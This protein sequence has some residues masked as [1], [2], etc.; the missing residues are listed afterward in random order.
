[1]AWQAETSKGNEAGKIKYEIVRY[2]RGR[3]LDLGSGP[4]KPYEHFISVDNLSEWGANWRP[5][6]IGDATDLSVFAN[7]SFDAVF[8]SHL[9]EHIEDYGHALEEWWRVI[10][11]KGYLVLYLPHKDY[12][13]NIGQCGANPDHK[14]DFLPRDIISEMKAVGYWD[15]VVNET[16]SDNDEYS[17][18][19][20]YKKENNGSYRFSCHEE[21]PRKSCGIVRYGGVGDMIQASSIFPGLKKLGYHITLYT[22]VRGQNIVKYDPYIDD[23]FIQ[24]NNQVPNHELHEFWNT[25]KKKHNRFIN[26][27]E[28]VEGTFLALPGRTQHNWPHYVRDKMLNYNYLEF[29]HLLANVPFIDNQRFY[30]SKEELCWAKSKKEEYGKCIMW[31]L[32]GSSVHKAWP[33]LDQTLA[34]IMITYPEFKVVLSG[35]EMCQI[36]ENGWENEDRI[37]KTSGRWS[38]RESLTFAQVADIVVGPETGILNSVANLDIP[39]IITLSHSSIENLTR[40]WVNCISLTPDNCRCYPCHMMQYG[41]THCFRDEETGVAECQAKISADKMTDAIKKHMRK[42]EVN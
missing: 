42:L 13:P 38:I 15:L 25:E 9:L 4:F 19:Q 14:H 35:D 20:V 41:F 7:E 26:L 39:K 8:S 12:Y 24:D 31:I 37:I 2:T 1:M 32:S 22:T 11:P 16:R 17:F 33:Y 5:D 23:F 27:S 30:P 34:R 6:I 28:S 10:K 18:F 21:R 40:D 36:L 29:A 3:V